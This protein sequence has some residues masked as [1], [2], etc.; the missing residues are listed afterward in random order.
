MRLYCLL[1]TRLLCT[2]CSSLIYWSLSM[3]EYLSSNNAQYLSS[4]ESCNDGIPFSSHLRNMT[5]YYFSRK[6]CDYFYQLVDFD[7]DEPSSKSVNG[8][9]TVGCHC[10][11][12]V[13]LLTNS[14]E[15]RRGTWTP[16]GAFAVLTKNSFHSISINV[17]T[18]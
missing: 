16:L 6:V 7:S 2:P 13:K 10:H 5:R 11:S 15:Y 17:M 3:D 14:R 18:L 12:G 8:N 1:C 4:V 9:A